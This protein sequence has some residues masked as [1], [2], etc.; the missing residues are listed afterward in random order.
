MDSSARFKARL[1]GRSDRPAAAEAD[2]AV[3]VRDRARRVLESAMGFAEDLTDD[4]P[5]DGVAAALLSGHAIDVDGVTLEARV[6]G[7]RLVL[8]ATVASFELTSMALGIAML[9]ANSLLEGTCQSAWGTRAGGRGLLLR[10]SHDIGV[11][12]ASPER[13]EPWARAVA[14]L[15]R[16]VAQGA[17]R[18]TISPSIDRP[19]TDVAAVLTPYA[20]MPSPIEGAGAAELHAVAGRF[21]AALMTPPEA[22]VRIALDPESRLVLGRLVQ[23][24]REV[25]SARM[26]RFV[27]PPCEVAE[28][29]D[30]LCL[31]GETAFESPGRSMARERDGASMCWSIDPAVTS[32]GALERFVAE[33]QGVP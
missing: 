14:A 7:T 29:I 26:V 8:V 2:P 30:A 13:L 18:P 20:C 16:R 24:G 25:L 4:V 32:S 28:A 3:P 15:V 10:T 6:V 17:A 21:G 27:A 23:N 12:A 11:L 19:G 5:A 33:S 31:T 1:T 22:G 9:E